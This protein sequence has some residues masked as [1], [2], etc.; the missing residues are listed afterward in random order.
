M[1]K[2]SQQD[3]A[4]NAVSLCGNLIYLTPVEFLERLKIGKP[5]TVGRDAL[6]L[7]K[8]FC[9]TKNI[10]TFFTVKDVGSG[11]VEIQIPS[12]LL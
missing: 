2:T 11:N 10:Q 7:F 5:I 1:A 9:A 6:S 3:V 12:A 8:N 4:G